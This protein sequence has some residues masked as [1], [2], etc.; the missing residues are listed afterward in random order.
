ML[1]ELEVPEVVELFETALLALLL[2][3]VPLDSPT[4]PPP[5]LPPAVEPAMTEA[6]PL[7]LPPYCS[8]LSMSSRKLAVGSTAAPPRLLTTPVGSAM[9]LAAA[10]AAN[11]EEDCRASTFALS[12]GVEIRDE[13]S[14]R[15]DGEATELGIPA[16]ASIACTPPNM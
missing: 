5:P 7:P 13:L 8:L 12:A 11:E 9:K 2:T 10:A 16:V 6:T 1:T 3:A 15:A 4:L 14:E